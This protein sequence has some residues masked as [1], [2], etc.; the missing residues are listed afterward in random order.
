MEESL[1]EGEADPRVFS[2]APSHSHY[3]GEPAEA[4][5]PSLLVGASSSAQSL[6]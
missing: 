4:S 1:F 6:V 2:D 5:F 3:S